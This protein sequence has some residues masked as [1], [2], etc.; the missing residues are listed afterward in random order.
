MLVE[1]QK[2]DVGSKNTDGGRVYPRL[3]YAHS[4]FHLDLLRTMQARYSINILTQGH[5]HQIL[6]S[7]NHS[8]P[9]PLSRYRYDVISHALLLCESLY[10]RNTRD[11][12]VGDNPECCQP[13]L[14]EDFFWSTSKISWKSLISHPQS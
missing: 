7:W 12:L 1:N 9:L 10:Q 5:H 11:I 14:D 13:F 4:T 6:Q 3:P 2:E 8:P